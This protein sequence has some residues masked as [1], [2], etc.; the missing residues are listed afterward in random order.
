M[1]ES[2][3]PYMEWAKKRPKAAI[4]LALSNILACTLSDLPGAREAVDLAGDSPDGYTPLVQAIAQSHGVA[5]EDVTTAGG[6]SGANFLA[7]AALVEGGEEI[8]IESPNYDPIPGAARML[9][10]GVSSFARR[11]DEGY[12]IDPDRVAAAVGPDTRLIVVT[13][14]HNPSGVLASEEE[15]AGLARVAEKTG[16]PVLVD[17]VYLDTVLENR[18][19]SAATRSPLFVATSSLTKA[20]GLAS[21]RCGWILASPEITRR[22]RRARDVMDVWSAIPA[23]RLSVVAFGHLNSLAKRTRRLV[24]DNTRLVRTFLAGRAELSCVESRSTIAFPRLLGV[25]DSTELVRRLFE[26]SG[27]AVVPGSFFDSPAHF[28]LSFG[29]ATEPLASGLAAIGQVLD[30][31]KSSS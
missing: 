22:I 29:G 27:V 1:T 11:F 3:A 17:E 20:Y 18:P 25:S 31:M 23:D 10:A 21:L 24:E 28:R 26:E 7:I 12:R 15:M 6:C 8:L 2:R 9:G 30:S 16:T 14:P 5:P 13:N 4:D 19:A